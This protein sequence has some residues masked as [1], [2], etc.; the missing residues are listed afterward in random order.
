M[1]DDKHI[2]N[3]KILKGYFYQSIIDKNV[4]LISKKAMMTIYADFLAYQLIN[5]EW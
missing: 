4:K 5:D 3:Q 1:L 2:K